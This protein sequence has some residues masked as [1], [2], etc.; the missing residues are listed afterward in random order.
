MGNHR[1]QKANKKKRKL[2]RS[3]Y[4]WEFKIPEEKETKVETKPKSN[5]VGDEE[6]KNYFEFPLN[7]TWGLV[8][9]NEGNKAFD[10]NFTGDTKIISEN[11]EKILKKLNGEENIELKPLEIINDKGQ[12]Y[13]NQDNKRKKLLLIRGWGNLTSPSCHGLTIEKACEIQD[14]FADFI[15]KKLGE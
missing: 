3:D 1:N 10:F 6:F 12:L 4:I 5:F 13:V 8:F 7:L 9:T 15:I 2:R 14:Q 11:Q